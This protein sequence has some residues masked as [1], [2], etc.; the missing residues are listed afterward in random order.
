[1][2]SSMSSPHQ[3]QPAPTS[4]IEIPELLEKIHAFIPLRTLRHSVIYVCRQWFLINRHHITPRELVWEYHYQNE[5]MSKAVPI[6]AYLGRIKLYFRSVNQEQCQVE[7]RQWKVF[8][9]ALKGTHTRR[10]QHLQQQRD[11]EQG[12]DTK[13]VGRRL[14]YEPTPI[15]DFSLSG[16]YPSTKVYELIPYLSHVTFLRIDQNWDHHVYPYKIFQ[17]CPHLLRL[18]VGSKT[19]VEMFGDWLP[20]APEEQQPFTLRELILH[21]AYLKQDRLEEF[22]GFTPHLTDLHLSNLSIKG[23]PVILPDQRYDCRALIAVIKSLG[24][25]LKTFHFSVYMRHQV[26]WD[27]LVDEDLFKSICQD[28]REWTF[29]MGDLTPQLFQNIQCLPNTITTLN[30]VNRHTAYYTPDSKLHL[31]LCTSPQ[32]LHLR[33]PRTTYHMSYLDLYRRIPSVVFGDRSTVAQETEAARYPVPGVWACRGLRTLHIAFETPGGHWTNIRLEYPRVAFGYIVKVCPALIELE[34]HAP[35][36]WERHAFQRYDLA[37]GFCLLAGLRDLERLRVPEGPQKNVD[38]L[39]DMDWM[40]SP[41]NLSSSTG[42]QNR[43]ER[44]KIVSQWRG[45]LLAEAHKD[46][47]R[48]KMLGDEFQ[49]H[50]VRLG[51]GL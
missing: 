8:F 17:G 5:S 44:R 2:T 38:K 35:N 47:K 30:M 50:E 39:H 27:A 16:T 36:N 7:N 11:Q 19:R 28:S 14:L 24:L 43:K 25:P 6:L 22:L 34:I 46:S 26:S 32:L 3:P 40:T 18:Y 29:A 10:L 31:F 33:I 4:P 48:L 51:Y 15:L 42:L 23:R 1:M 20:S 9:N 37:G 49:R 45:L 21:N 13:M 41:R 12:Q